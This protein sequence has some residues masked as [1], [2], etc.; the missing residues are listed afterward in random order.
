MTGASPQVLTETLFA[1]NH[2]GKT[3]PD[4]VFV[5]TTANSRRRVI[6]RWSMEQVNTRLSTSRHYVKF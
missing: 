3:M 5:I 4:E 1:L 2:Q 6:S